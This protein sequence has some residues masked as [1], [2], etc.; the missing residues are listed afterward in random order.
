MLDSN[1]G[2]FQAG[3]EGLEQCPFCPFATIMD[4]P[5]E[6]NKIFNCLNPECGKDSCRLCGEL[7]HIPLRCDEMEDDAVV[8]KRTY[9]E[10]KMAEAMI[11]HCYNCQ[12]PYIKLVLFEILSLSSEQNLGK[13]FYLGPLTIASKM[14]Y[15]VYDF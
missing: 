9:I 13:F 2:F 15:F 5:K 4:V 1:D 6:Q 3:L 10:N 8:R 7:S 11:R 14:V 12:R